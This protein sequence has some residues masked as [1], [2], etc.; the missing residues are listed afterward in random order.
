MKIKENIQF[1]TTIALWGQCSDRFLSGG[2]KEAT[3]FEDKIELISQIKDIKGVDLYGDWDV[4][5]D[6]VEEVKKIL[7]K[8][9]LKTYNVTADICSLREF[10][11]GSVT[12]P[13][14]KTRQLGWQKITEAIDMAKALNC[15]LVDLWFGQDG[16]DYSFQTDYMLAW[17]QIIDTV[18]KA[19]DYAGKD[20]K[21]ALEYKPREPRTHIFTA[22][23][24]K[25]LFIIEKAKKDNIGIVIDTGHA[26]CAG[27]NIAESAVICKMAQDKLYYIHLNDNYKVWDDDM[28]VGS[29]HPFEMFEFLYW[30]EKIDYNGPYVLDMFPY[31][32][33]PMEAARESIEFVKQLRN[34]LIEVDEEILIDLFNKQDA[35]AS[36]KFLRK[37]FIR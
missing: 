10:G 15:N 26:Y 17:Q 16:Y 32:E 33:D 7:K 24:T 37:Y 21:I 31:R 12:S 2:Y 30:L 18:A 19:A 35:T 23:A 9:N 27:E 22:S 6:N 4:S 29:I 28:M 25:M 11:K 3:S 5:K 36:M 20:I 8:Y 13:D 14:N 1:G 34:I